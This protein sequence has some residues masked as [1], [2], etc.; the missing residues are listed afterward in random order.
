VTFQVLMVSAKMFSGM[1]ELC[2]VVDID[3]CFRD[4]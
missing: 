3:Q 2:S 4:A 1:S